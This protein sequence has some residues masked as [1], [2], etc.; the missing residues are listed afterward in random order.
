MLRCYAAAIPFLAWALILQ[1]GLVDPD[2]GRV[3]FLLVEGVAVCFTISGL[4]A[5]YDKHR[6]EHPPSG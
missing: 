2:A 5:K 6:K 3:P 1:L 4:R